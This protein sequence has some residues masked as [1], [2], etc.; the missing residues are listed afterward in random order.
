MLTEVPSGLAFP[1]DLL[2]QAL[3]EALPLSARVALHK[4]RSRRTH[5]DRGAGG[6]V[7]GT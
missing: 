7:A 5:A 4:G 2:R 3:Y 1:H 6:A